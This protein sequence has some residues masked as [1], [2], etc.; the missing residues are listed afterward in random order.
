MLH[1]PQLAT[2]SQALDTQGGVCYRSPLMNR[3]TLV[4]VLA[5]LAILVVAAA[6][7]Y[8]LGTL[9]ETRFAASPSP[10][11][12]DVP[13]TTPPAAQSP[14]ASVPPRVPSGAPTGPEAP[15]DGFRVVFHPLPSTVQVGLTFPVQWE[16]YGPLGAAGRA[17]TRLTVA[18]E[19]G[20][21]GVGDWGPVTILPNAFEATVSIP[22]VGNALLIAEVFVDGQIVR[23]EHW[24]AAQ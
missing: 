14:K 22:E 7:G 10:K 4:V 19:H 24:I 17:H 18:P 23:A 20:E 16:V 9:V 1:A 2:G 5:G 21:P 12:A 3:T 13:A 8:G 15:A 11:L 6:V